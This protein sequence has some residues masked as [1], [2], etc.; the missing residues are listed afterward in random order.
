MVMEPSYLDVTGLNR[1]QLRL[2]EAA[3]RAGYAWWGMEPEPTGVV[4][5]GPDR[6]LYVYRGRGEGATVF[7]YDQ[8]G[9]H[10]VT[11]KV[12]FTLL[13]HRAL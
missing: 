5:E 12:A 8:S 10:R 4:I 9:L 13:H 6:Y 11:Q 7:V 2:V 1:R 3:E